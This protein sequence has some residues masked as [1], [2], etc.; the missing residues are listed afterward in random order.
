[1]ELLAAERTVDDAPEVLRRIRRL[2]AH[3]RATA[4]TLPAWCEAFVTTGYA[5]YCTL[6]PTAFVDE[7]TGVR[8]VAAM[9]GFLFS[10][11]SLALSL[12]CDRP[13][14]SSPCASPI[15][16]RRPRSAL[17]WAARHQLGLLPL[18]ELRAR[19]A[20][21]LANPLVVPAFPQYL[22]GFV[23]A[24]E[25]V[26]GLAPFVV[27]TMS[28][29]FARLPDPVLLPWLPTL[30][31]TLR[32]HGPELVPLLVREAGRTFPGTLPA[33]DAWVPPWLAPGPRPRSRRAAGRRRAG[34]CPAGR[35]PGGRRRGRRAAR[36]RGRMAPARRWPPDVGALL[37]A[38][39][40]TVEAVAACS[41][42]D[43]RPEEVVNRGARD[44]RYRRPPP[45]HRRRVVGLP[46]DGA[47][48]VRC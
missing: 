26:P 5:H 17:L 48:A 31:T 15:R 21:L 2:L 27:E 14:W 24:L 1:M 29:A 13:S 30:I 25:P 36:R 47:V 35:P 44:G 16:R 46:A 22:T 7:E 11:E 20:E 37:A 10:M 45:R 8:Q 42:T 9:L 38:Y 39:P 6:L 19:C 28:T 4:P 34:A 32:E 12:G 41:S 18:A 33:L 3:Y 43:E 23:Q 40:A